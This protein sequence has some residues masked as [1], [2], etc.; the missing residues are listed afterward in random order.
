MDILTLRW[1][2]LLVGIPCLLLIVG[3]CVGVGMMLV[4]GKG[5]KSR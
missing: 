5:T 3:A 1:V 4:R 2:I